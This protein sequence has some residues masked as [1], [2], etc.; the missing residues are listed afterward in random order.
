MNNERVDRLLQ[1]AWLEGWINTHGAY[2]RAMTNRKPHVYVSPTSRNALI[3]QLKSVLAETKP[4]VPLT[5]GALLREMR[6]TQSLRSQEIFSRLGVTQ[7]IYRMMEQDAIS[8][9]KI[10]AN[11]W[12][13][14]MKLLNL[15]I[16]EFANTIRQT[17]QLVFFR[18]SIKGV[19]ARY[20]TGKRKSL[21]SSTLEKAYA[22]M[23]VKA[24]LTIPRQDEKKLDDLIA[25]L[26]DAD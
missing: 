22:E 13:K 10:S 1:L 20:K 24:K 26:K 3:E 4:A 16:D 12:K 18:P 2:E 7:N 6:A 21:K 5:V 25:T 9:L 8:P 11:V 15:P 23:Y 19:L 17:H 14:L